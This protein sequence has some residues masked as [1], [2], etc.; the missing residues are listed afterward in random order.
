MRIIKP[1][2]TAPINPLR[3]VCS[4][5]SKATLLLASSTS[6]NAQTNHRPSLLNLRART[7]ATT[8]SANPFPYPTHKSPTPHQIF[9]LPHSATENDIKARY[10]DLVRIYHPDKASNTVSPEIAHERFQAITTAYDI[11]RGRKPHLASR[12]TSSGVEDRSYQTTAAYRA[13]RRRRQE[14]YSS[15]AIDDRWKDRI[16]LGLA[17]ATVG[18][19]VMQMSTTRRTAVGD[20]MMEARRPGGS[21]SSS[22]QQ[23]SEEE[24]RLSA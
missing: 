11:L 23:P 5:R 16:F 19:F 17:F 13:A 8:S 10:F 2:P 20:M 4:G 12:P 18:V 14:L 15:G 6:A 9:H 1:R 21:Y 7:Y 24:K 22:S 3:S